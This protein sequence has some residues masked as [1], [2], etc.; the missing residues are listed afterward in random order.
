[1]ID[2]INPV[3]IACPYCGG[4]FETQVDSSAGN[5]VYYEDCAIC[6]CPILLRIEIDGQGTLS[7][8]E[9]LREDE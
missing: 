9:A 2:M 8:I 7:R 6:C 4:Q 3:D 1:M 5:Q